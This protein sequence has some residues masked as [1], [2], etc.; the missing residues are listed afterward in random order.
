MGDEPPVFSQQVYEATVPENLPDALLTTVV[1]TD[2]DTKPE[3]TYIM[4]NGDSQLFSVE[5]ETG[6]V[7]TYRGLD[8]EASPRHTI[9]I[10]T[11]ENSQGG[12]Q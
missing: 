12:S 9:I 7:S 6:Q 2:P 10:G 1:A 5:P 3:I 11:L 4:V 8:Y